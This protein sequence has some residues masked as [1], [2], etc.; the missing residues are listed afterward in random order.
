MK[1]RIAASLSSLL[2]GFFV[3]IGYDGID[4]LAFFGPTVT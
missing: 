3:Y 4:L 2:W 1:R